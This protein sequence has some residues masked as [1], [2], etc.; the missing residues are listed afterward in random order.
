MNGNGGLSSIP[1]FDVSGIDVEND[2]Y[3]YHVFH[4]AAR[5][6][7]A[8]ANSGDSRNHVMW[9]GVAARPL[10]SLSADPGHRKKQP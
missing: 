4:F 8:R 9:R 3:H 1:V 10:A 2:F 5:E 7:I 6:R